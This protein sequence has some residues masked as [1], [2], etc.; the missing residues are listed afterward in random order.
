MNYHI[1]KDIVKIIIQH[2]GKR[3]IIL[4]QDLCPELLIH[5]I[6]NN[7]EEMFILADLFE[8]IKV[9][10]SNKLCILS[11]AGGPGVLASDSC[12]ETGLEIVEL[13]NKILKALNEVLPSTWSENSC[14]CSLTINLR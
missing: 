8:H 13:P 9:P 4:L 14:V 2:A 12:E 11:N 7:L 6:V 5:V 1:S 3:E 10:K